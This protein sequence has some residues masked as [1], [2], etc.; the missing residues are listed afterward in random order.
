VRACIKPFL[1]LFLLLPLTAWPATGSGA[2]SSTPAAA[3][4]P[5][6]AASPPVA[7]ASEP[8]ATTS[9]PAA[10]VAGAS[11]PPEG[12]ASLPVPAA[13]ASVPAGTAQAARSAAATSADAASEDAG[14]LACRPLCDPGRPP[15]TLDGAAVRLP[16]A[17][18]GRAYRAQIAASGGLPP[19]LFSL[20]GG[21]LP[22]G[23][24][25]GTDGV[26]TGK[27]SA[28]AWRRLAVA[29]T[30]A[31]GHR[32]QRGYV[33]SV[34][35]PA[36]ASSEPA[37][38]APAAPPSLT[39]LTA[40]QARTPLP[41]VTPIV[42]YEV[43]EDLIK[44]IA[45]PALIIQPGDIETKL[46][47]DARAQM[48]QLLAPLTGV[49]YPN[50]RLFA[51]ALDARVCAYTADLLRATAAAQKIV[52]S[53][54]QALEAVCPG[55]KPATPSAS[56][57][58][59]GVAASA[60]PPALTAAVPVAQ[61]T[62]TVLPPEWRTFVISGARHALSISTF[63]VP[64]WK[65]TGCNC[66]I[67]SPATTVYGFYPVWHGDA[68]RPK[69]DWGVYDRIDLF[70]QL[71]DRDGN[72]TPLPVEEPAVQTFLH[73]LHNHGS[74]LDI[75][76]YQSDWQF[77][78]HTSEAY[79]LRAIQQVATQVVRQADTPMPG[80]Q[81]QWQ[82]WLPGDGFGSLQRTASGITVYLEPPQ[83]AALLPAFV[84]FR[85]A[86]VMQLVEALHASPYPHV[87]NL[88]LND[89]ELVATRTGKGQAS[90]AASATS[91]TTVQISDLFAYLVLAE[92][93][94][95]EEG[96]IR[97]Q[98]MHYRSNTSI[99][100]RFLVM[101]PEPVATSA[102]RLR[103]LVESD[104]WLLG[105]NQE[106]LL[107]K[108]VP[109]V[110]VGSGS[111]SQFANSMAYF[112][113]NFGGVALWQPPVDL[114]GPAGG[115]VADSSAPATVQD[116]L[117]QALR[118]SFLAGEPSASAAC[119][120]V[121][122]WHWPL[123]ALFFLLLFIMFGLFMAYGFSSR[124]RAMGLP[125]QALLLAGSLVTIING[126]ALLQCDPG[127]RFVRENNNILYTLLAVLLLCALV[128]MLRPRV[129]NP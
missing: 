83:D 28:R 31:A 34:Q 113:G 36:A 46:N 95:I 81:V 69:V 99:T 90:A 97:S 39:E 87:L 107:G 89:D 66:L 105:G 48:K 57:P 116:T 84:Q 91:A 67:E 35:V 53:P 40:Q 110:S 112:H 114:P 62:A 51:A 16:T 80:W 58:V 44:S 121:C 26:I 111:A 43:T 79:R 104:P 25:F 2:G 33:L 100:L 20:V 3:A 7:T 13:P 27:P 42:V 125:Y 50:Q 68:A 70:A 120:W 49:E 8:A 41:P 17:R 37:A 103:Q 64:D 5:A 72:I 38:S 10:A 94:T 102:R 71:F 78:L 88:V 128:P 11:I 47:S 118:A 123:R 75:A 21:K 60:P 106:I 124:I 108:L 1:P 52:M 24:V 59:P 55:A 14:D 73:E 30:D 6:P 96:H 19:Y 12:A 115:A 119:S 129:E 65:G 54:P 63:N 29:V 77:L 101:L 61:L 98:G 56:A 86:L 117:T 85:N 23:L 122:D 126:A 22:A 74:E 127:L 9:A 32:V 109:L 45:D 82:R 4:S 92:D 15:L 18:V 93:P 76:L